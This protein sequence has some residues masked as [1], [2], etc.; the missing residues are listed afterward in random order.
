[1]FSIKSK[2][3]FNVSYYRHT[4]QKFVHAKINT[5]LNEMNAWKDFHT[6]ACMSVM[7]TCVTGL[8]LKDKSAQHLKS[9]SF[10]S[11]DALMSYHNF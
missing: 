11:Q 6:F 8:V 7:K 2:L 3:I 1:M 9:F 5:Y 10:S 4:T